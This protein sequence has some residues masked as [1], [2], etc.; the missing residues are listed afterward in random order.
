VVIVER[1]GK[2]RVV[3]EEADDNKLDMESVTIPT[4]GWSSNLARAT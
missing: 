2:A 4:Q 3:M 1:A